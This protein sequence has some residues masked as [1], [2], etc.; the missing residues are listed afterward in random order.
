MVPAVCILQEL[1]NL[2]D[3]EAAVMFI[4]EQS[5]NLDKWDQ[6]IL[7]KCLDEVILKADSQC[8]VLTAEVAKAQKERLFFQ[9]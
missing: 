5:G 2:K 6:W 3:E 9:I 4:S 8:P 7:D 1:Q